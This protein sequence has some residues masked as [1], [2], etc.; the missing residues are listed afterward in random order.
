MLKYTCVALFAA[1]QAALGWGIEGHS[2]VARIAEA[3]LTQAA[4]ERVAAI[5]GPGRSLASVASWADDFRRTHAETANWHFVDIPIN[6]RHLNMDRDCP[7][8]DCVVGRIVL[9]EQIV[10]DPAAT[11]AEREE[12]LKFLV[13]FIGDM[14]Q[15]LHCSTNGDRGGNTVRLIYR[16]MP[17]NLH[18]LWDTG[19]LGRMGT[20]EQLFPILSAEALQ[21]AGKWSKGDVQ[22]WAEQSHKASQKIVYGKLP[23]PPAP[24]QPIVIPPDYERTATSLVR[25]QLE[26]AGDRLARVLNDLFK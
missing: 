3:Q 6:Q 15:P 21:H 24:D 19:L 5:L 18:S 25:E 4:R 7:K 10:G 16:N 2:L 9:F 8:G 22:D 1:A 20:E 11:A 23:A 17:T 14:H 12:A 26:K 13:H